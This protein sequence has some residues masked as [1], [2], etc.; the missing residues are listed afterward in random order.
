MCGSDLRELLRHFNRPSVRR[1][2]SVSLQIIAVAGAEVVYFPRFLGL[3][4]S[5]CE[6]V[7][8]KVHGAQDTRAHCCY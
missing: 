2:R 6:P 4:V 1:F 5:V 3:F 7:M 8:N